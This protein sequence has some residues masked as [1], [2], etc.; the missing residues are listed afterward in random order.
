MHG[1]VVST[2]NAQEFTHATPISHSMNECGV[3]G[4]VQ[5]FRIMLVLSALTQ[6][7]NLLE[8]CIKEAV[9]NQEIISL[10]TIEASHRRLA[11]EVRA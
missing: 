8:K 7:T 6:V 1:A 9:S 4:S 5:G 10:Q 3:A 11:K 2:N